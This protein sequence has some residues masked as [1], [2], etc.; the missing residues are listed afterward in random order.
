VAVGCKFAPDDLGWDQWRDL[1]VIAT[2]RQWMQEQ[3]RALRDAIRE[4]T[5]QVQEGMQAARKAAGVP[6][7][8]QSLFGGKSADTKPVVAKRRR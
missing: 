2:E 6:G 8:G 5:R 3:V 4:D 7:P 1:Q